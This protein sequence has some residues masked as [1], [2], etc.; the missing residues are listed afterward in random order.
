VPY[1][2]CAEGISFCD[3][4]GAATL[5]SAFG[6][7]PNANGQQEL[8]EQVEILFG[9]WEPTKTE[10]TSFAVDLCKTSQPDQ[11]ILVSIPPRAS[12]SETLADLERKLQASKLS[13]ARDELARVDVLLIPNLRFD[14]THHFLEL[15][16]KSLGNAAFPDWMIRTAC[17]ALRFKLDRCGAGMQA[18]AKI[19]VRPAV[20]RR[21][22]F[23]RPFLIVMRKRGAQHPFFVMWVDNAELLCKP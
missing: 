6:N 8:C 10:H 14:L 11:L 12:L 18:E 2:E 1:A 20:P 9:G 21:F 15:E 4:N 23:D 17:Q 22:V 16:G 13:K 5:A 3:S 7:I 19:E